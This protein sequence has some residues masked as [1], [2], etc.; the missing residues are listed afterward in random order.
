MARVN[1]LLDRGLA[2]KAAFGTV[3]VLFCAFPTAP[4]LSEPHAIQDC[5]SALVR[6]AAASADEMDTICRGAG[7]AI[8]RLGRC[9]ILQQRAIEVE[10][11]D[12]VRNPFG[13]P[14]FGRFDLA[15]EVVFVA[16]LGKLESLIGD[17]PYG[18]LSRTEF[19][20]SLVVHEVV[21]ALMHQNYRRQPT[22]RAA[23][24]YP[25][26]AI[27]LESIVN[28]LGGGILLAAGAAEGGSRVLFNDVVL[29]FDPFFFAT[30]AYEHFSSSVDGC[31]ILQRLL[32]GEVEF[33]V[34]LP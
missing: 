24:E 20:R 30:R 10:V 31:A 26:Y 28:T 2:A 17:L 29:G 3:L 11:A 16:K 1:R 19:Y 7:E 21:H 13:T 12:T 18:R 22:S 14:I 32:A 9:G 33:I 27:Q 8:A 25:A 15:S 6:V 23:Y 5:P 34:T 4:V